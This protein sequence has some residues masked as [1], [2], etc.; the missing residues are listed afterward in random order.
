MAQ[1]DEYDE[2]IGVPNFVLFQE[3]NII[4]AISSDESEKLCTQL[5][6]S[7]DEHLCPDI[8]RDAFYNTK[9]AIREIFRLWLLGRG[10][11]P[12]SWSTLIQAFHTITLATATED[13]ISKLELLSSNLKVSG[14]TAHELPDA[15]FSSQ[16][17]DSKLQS[18]NYKISDPPDIL[19]LQNIGAFEA[20]PNEHEAATVATYL[21]MDYNGSIWNK[22]KTDDHSMEERNRAVFEKWLRKP[23]TWNILIDVLNKSQLRTLSENIVQL[24]EPCILHSPSYQYSYSKFIS[25]NKIIKETYKSQN[26]IQ[27]SRV[28]KSLQNR[29]FCH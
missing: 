26:I 12:I 8:F 6:T 2:I 18:T 20:I 1:S 22:I 7:S 17:C 23:V 25:Y 9:V 28:Q 19:A 24:I 5:L 3:F 10:K 11:Q 4:E 21:L 16:N 29:D 13:L 15:Q 14:S 27:F